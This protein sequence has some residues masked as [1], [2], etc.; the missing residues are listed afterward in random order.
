MNCR[1][2]SA[3][4]PISLD[5]LTSSGSKTLKTLPQLEIALTIFLLG[6]I[7]PLL[8]SPHPHMSAIVRYPLRNSVVKRRGRCGH[9][10]AQKHYPFE[11]DLVSLCD[12]SIHCEV[13]KLKLECCCSKLLYMNQGEREIKD[14]FKDSP[15]RLDIQGFKVSSCHLLAVDGYKHYSLS[16]RTSLEWPWLLGTPHIQCSRISCP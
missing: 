2:C 9:F 10:H 7:P 15:S 12:R 14:S 4:H 11:G 16:R 8:R 6:I 5:Y 13:E 1:K 3:T